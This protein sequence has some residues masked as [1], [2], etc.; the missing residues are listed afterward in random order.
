MSSILSTFIRIALAKPSMKPA[1]ATDAKLQ[2][3][4]P[5]VQ[6]MFIPKKAQIPATV[7]FARFCFLF[8]K[9]W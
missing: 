4:T 2:I 9:D 8:C 1:V 6:A 5:A 3:V 7:Y